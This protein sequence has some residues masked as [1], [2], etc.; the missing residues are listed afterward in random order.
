MAVNGG[1]LGWRTT[2]RY[3][4]GQRRGPL[5]EGQQLQAYLSAY[6]SSPQASVPLQDKKGS[7]VS[8][9]F[10]FLLS[11]KISFK[12][13][14]FKVFGFFS[15]RIFFYFSSSEVQAKSIKKSARKKSGCNFQNFYFKN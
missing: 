4:A 13:V 14:Q 12:F 8:F 10:F 11:I 1:R 5:K 15:F 7:E 6:Y 3:D 9:F 2:T